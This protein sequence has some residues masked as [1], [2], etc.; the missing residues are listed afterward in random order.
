MKQPKTGKG[1]KRSHLELKFLELWTALAQNLTLSSEVCCIPN[2]K[3][4]FDFRIDNT[5]LLIEING[6]V[7]ANKR[8]GH[9]TGAGIQRDAEKARLAVYNGFVVIT[10][11][12]KDLTEKHI[13]E[14][15]NHARETYFTSQQPT[16][17]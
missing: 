3:F 12:S 14:L 1:K 16:L 10:F 5:P 9:S 7:F 17:H 15:I 8:Y 13:K 11:T 4:R 2:R 6:G